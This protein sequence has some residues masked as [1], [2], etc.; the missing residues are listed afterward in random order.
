[1]PL[2]RARVQGPRRVVRAALVTLALLAAACTDPVGP[3]AGPPTPVSISGVLTPEQRAVI[4]GM[5]VEVTGPGIPTPI[6][7]VLDVNATSVNGIVHVPAGPDRVFTVRAFD[8]SGNEVYGGSATSNVVPGD[9]PTLSV[10][11]LPRSGSV[12][13]DVTI[14]GVQLLVTPD[15]TD[16]A[17][18]AQATLVATVSD[19]SGALVSAGTVQWGV[20]NPTLVQITPSPN[21]RSLTVRGLI[22]G[23]TRVVAMIDG[24]ATAAVLVIGPGAGGP[25]PLELAS[26]SA[27]ATHTC[28]LTPLGVAYCWGHNADG[29]LGDGTQVDRAAPTRV[30]GSDGP[31][32]VAIA[33]G[34]AHTCGIRSGGAMYCWGRNSS[35][36][37]G[38]GT[39]VRRL[40]P[41]LVP[42]LSVNEMAVGDVHTCAWSHSLGG[43]RGPVWCWGDNSSGQL[44]DGTLTG[45]N[46]PTPIVAEF[47]GGRALRAGGAHTCGYLSQGASSTTSLRCWGSNDFRQIDNTTEFFRTT[48]TVPDPLPDVVSLASGTWFSCGLNAAGQ[49]TCWGLNDNGQLGFTSGSV[50]GPGAV[51]G[52]HA[53][54]ALD[55]G[56]RTSC[57]LTSGGE[58]WCWGANDQGQLGNGTQAGGATPVRV[59]SIAMSSV[60]VGDAHS[61]GIDTE[62]EAWCWGANQFGQLGDGTQQRRLVPVRVMLR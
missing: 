17:V 46:A 29:Q 21:G 35:G 34:F 60:T 28:G 61:C 6:V 1:M 7:A 8:G 40:E 41:T 25:A 13:I 59:S 43:D 4:A 16:V 19:G 14:G 3:V 20:V 47:S 39:F 11:L 53:F 62:G 12:P 44:G 45:R 2:V 5:S 57:G 50:S 18:G 56:D 36:Q 10:R 51:S 37:L 31:T 52:G 38:D 26:I 42:N 27:G 15:S 9:N 32:F 33:T 48:P 23:K 24:V 22:P 54:T 55:A 49:A 58:I 30:G